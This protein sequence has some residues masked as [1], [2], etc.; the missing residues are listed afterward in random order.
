[1]PQQTTEQL[2]ELAKT[3]GAS[4]N[5]TRDLERAQTYARLNLANL[6]KE[7]VAF[8]DAKMV[9]GMCMIKLTDL[10]MPLC[11]SRSAAC[12]LRDSIIHD[13]AVRYVS[14]NP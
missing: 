13:T 3:L 2:R 14:D 8:K 11:S 6:C 9:A 12:H 7:M 5:P 10:C 1:M 4:T